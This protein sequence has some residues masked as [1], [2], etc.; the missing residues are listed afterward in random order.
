[1]T[2]AIKPFHQILPTTSIPNT[3]NIKLQLQDSNCEFGV[4]EQHLHSLISFPE[5]PFQSLGVSKV[6]VQSLSR[7]CSVMCLF[8]PQRSIT[9]INKNTTS[10]HIKRELFSYPRSSHWS[11]CRTLHIHLYYNFCFDPFFLNLSNI[12]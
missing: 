5:F 3:K 6:V 2:V 12:L 9:R 7:Y 8:I 10:Y 4:S 1:M 11:V